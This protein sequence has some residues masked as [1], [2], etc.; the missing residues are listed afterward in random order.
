MCS[1][2]HLHSHQPLPIPFPRRPAPSWL[3]QGITPTLSNQEPDPYPAHVKPVQP[4][5]DA[6]PDPL[7]P[8]AALP[9]EHAL[10]HGGHGGVVPLLDGLQ[11]LGE[12]VVVVVYLGRPQGGR[13]RWGK[14]AGGRQLRGHARDGSGKEEARAHRRSMGILNL[15]PR[16][17]P[18]P[19]LP[20]PRDMSPIPSP[21]GPSCILGSREGFRVAKGT[22]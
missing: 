11:E 16:P 19:P 7:P 22:L 12:A 9:L 1:A 4:L 17:N 18:L 6:L 21:T 8:P 13:W 2:Q 10:R 3:P 14:V 20:G 15:V 5:L